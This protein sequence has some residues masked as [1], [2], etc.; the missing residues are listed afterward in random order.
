MEFDG[1]SVVVGGCGV[2]GAALLRDNGVWGTDRELR[3][4]S[5]EFGGHPLALVPKAARNG[6]AGLRG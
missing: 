6:R 1:V 5:R 4:A 3:A 2:D